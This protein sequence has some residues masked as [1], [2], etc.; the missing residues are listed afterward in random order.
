MKTK[1]VS[2]ITIRRSNERGH[3]DHG[4]LLS[5]HTF[6]FADYYDPA[7]MSYQSLRVINDD[8][9]APG[10]G[11]GMHPHS[12]ME[13]FTYVISGKLKHEDSMG[14]GRTIRAGEFQYM[15]AGDGVL[16]SETNPSDEETHLLQIW[17][18]PKAPGGEPRYADMNPA[19]LK[20]KNALTL[21]A[22]GD[23]R[24][25]SFEIRQN[26]EISFG[27]LHKGAT[28]NQHSQTEHPYMWL[29]LIKGSVTLGTETLEAGDAA[30]L[31]HTDLFLS[32]NQESEFL[33]FQLN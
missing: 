12:S 19:D 9:I 23:G 8:Y 29:Q 28:L 3:A 30:A 27:H 14:N 13:I 33:L 17:I 4:W 6:S 20:K 5:W 18:T 22:S 26:A 11:F 7:H 21:L 1:Q 10:K 24:D 15:S 32:A 31:D 2:K 25:G 16:H